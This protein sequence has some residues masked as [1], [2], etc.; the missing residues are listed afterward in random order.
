MSSDRRPLPALRGTDPKT[1]EIVLHHPFSGESIVLAEADLATL[2]QWKTDV[3]EW[4]EMA[5]AAERQVD[6]EI[7]MRMD[8][9]ALWTARQGGFKLE[10]QSNAPS[11]S[12]VD[13]EE[14]RRKLLAYV[15]KG[16]ITIEAVE[17]ALPIQPE[18]VTVRLAGLNNL[19]KLGGK[20][21]RLVRRHR[22][23]TPKAERTVKVSSGR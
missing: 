9:A 11:Y 5:R 15:E 14:L 21:E 8:R 1:G 7:T 3:K 23:E 6:R 17:A 12:Y 22:K 19:L 16:E 10:G 13:I 18:K 20:V 2:A 4:V